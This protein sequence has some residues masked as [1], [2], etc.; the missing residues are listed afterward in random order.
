MNGRKGI[1]ILTIAIVAWLIV[2]TREVVSPTWKVLVT[3]T[4]NRPI[5][6]ASVTAYEQQYTLESKDVEQ[7]E[8]TGAD[9]TVNFTPRFIWANGMRR[10]RS[11]A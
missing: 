5:S 7:T 11:P 10:L 3:D 1:T 4:S 6:G 9:G 8:I 2:P